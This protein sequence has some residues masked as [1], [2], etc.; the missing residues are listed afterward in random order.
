MSQTIS[1]PDDFEY[2]LCPECQGLGIYCP[3]P[4]APSFAQR[5]ETCVECKGTGYLNL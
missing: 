4:E 1:W 3:N 5:D 2:E